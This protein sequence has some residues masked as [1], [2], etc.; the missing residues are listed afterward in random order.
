MT[1]RALRVL[2]LVVAAGAIVGCG[3]K[4]QVVNYK[5]GQYQG[6]PDTPAWGSGQFQGDR[7]AW[8]KAINERALAQNEYVRIKN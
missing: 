2:S 5:Q 6:K 4:P 1:V 3:E 8:E 7:T